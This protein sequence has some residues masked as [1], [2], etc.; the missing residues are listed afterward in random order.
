MDST[1]IP[2]VNQDHSDRAILASRIDEAHH[3]TQAVVK[4]GLLPSVTTADDLCRITDDHPRQTVRSLAVE[5]EV[6]AVR[7]IEAAK[8]TPNAAVVRRHALRIIETCLS[9]CSTGGPTA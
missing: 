9:L 4:E 6:L 5:M 7:T 2:A 1:S 3:T 8:G